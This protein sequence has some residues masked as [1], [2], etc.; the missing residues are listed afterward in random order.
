M[1]RG[2]RLPEDVPP[3]CPAGSERAAAFSSPRTVS[4]DSIPSPSPGVLSSKPPSPGSIQPPSDKALTWDDM[5]DSHRLLRNSVMDMDAFRPASLDEHDHSYA[6]LSPVPAA[7]DGFNTDFNNLF[8]LEFSDQSTVQSSDCTDRCTPVSTAFSGSGVGVTGENDSVA[9]CCPNN[10]V[11]AGSRLPWP[12]DQFPGSEM[13]LEMGGTGLAKPRN[14]PLLSAVTRSSAAADSLASKADVQAATQLSAR[15]DASPGSRM[16]IVV[17]EAK[18]E[19]LVEVMKVL[20]ESQARVE[21]RR[22]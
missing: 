1:R 16:T 9:R 12:L 10:D 15:G 4:P 21:F 19:T 22:E 8:G 11:S 17:D 14:G 5:N 3:C 6:F 2:V 18:P 20:M 7:D 13:D